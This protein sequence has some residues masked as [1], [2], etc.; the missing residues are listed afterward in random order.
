MLADVN[1]GNRLVEPFTPPIPLPPLAMR[2]LVSPIVDESY[3]DN[4]SGDFIWGPLDIGPLRPGAAY[5]RIL[6]F[7]CGCG[8]EAR[9][10]LLQCE[11]PKTY[12]GV[13]IS[14][15]MIEWC[16]RNLRHDGFRFHHH[17]VWSISYAPE[18]SHNRRLPIAH[19]GSDF[20]IVEANSVFTHLHDDQTQ[21]YLEE[22]RSM[23][24]PQ[25]II[26][27]SWFF[28][29]K[30]CFPVM[31]DKLNTL[32]VSENDPTAAVYYDWYYFIKLTRSLGYR[33][34]RIEWADMLGFH[35]I[36]CLA[37]SDKFPDLGETVP[38]GSSV[39]GF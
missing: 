38:P 8:R 9:R 25:G 19:L 23:L 7:G 34:A 1:P 39:L 24:A 33:I 10:L 6:D 13:D 21:F 32:F 17:D 5:G 31:T 3:Y 22:M 2:G 11:K 14:K 35:N 37:L 29:N 12:V 36:V 28:F 20:T 16:Q 27:A 30:K 26:R 4:P 18:N 15:T